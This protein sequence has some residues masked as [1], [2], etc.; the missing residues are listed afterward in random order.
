[1]MTV[2]MIK[3]SQRILMTNQLVG[4][5]FVFGCWCKYDFLN[6][7]SV[8]GGVDKDGSLHKAEKEVDWFDQDFFVLNICAVSS[9][10]MQQNVVDTS[11][12]W[13]PVHHVLLY[14]VSLIA[15]FSNIDPL[16]SFFASPLKH[17]FDPSSTFFKYTLNTTRKLTPKQC[18]RRIVPVPMWVVGPWRW[19]ESWIRSSFCPRS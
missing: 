7:W 8:I 9:W 17:Q 4:W 14:N 18:R 3:W 19:V 12:A 16:S 15:F 10:W 13:E 6:G 2:M 5:R 1:M 11:L